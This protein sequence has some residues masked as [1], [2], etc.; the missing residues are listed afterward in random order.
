MDT[1]RLVTIRT[2]ANEREILL[3]S[4]ILKLGIIFNTLII[5]S[6]GYCQPSQ[7]E[8]PTKIE[9]PPAVNDTGSWASINGGFH[10]PI[11][12]SSDSYDRPTY[13][14]WYVSI[15]HEIRN[16][17]FSF[18]IE[19]QYWRWKNGDSRT[20]SF[21]LSVSAKLRYTIYPLRIYG[22]AGIGSGS[23]I[24]FIINWP[25]ALGAE[26]VL[27]DHLGLNLQLRRGINLGSEVVTLCILG[28]ALRE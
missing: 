2:F 12:R 22:Q 23:N 9:M 13:R 6:F 26:L 1:T 15:G 16:E 17:Y 7:I 20:S 28:I 14:N 27:S 10:F 4:I 18:P 8:L 25:Y 11:G 5:F 24:G 3:M 19:F 21:L